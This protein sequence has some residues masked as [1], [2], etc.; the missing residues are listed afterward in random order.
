MYTAILNG[1]RITKVTP[2]LITEIPIKTNTNQINFSILYDGR[3]VKKGYY[4]ENRL[5]LVKIPGNAI[6]T[7]KSV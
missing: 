3:Q 6:S 2:K 7:S 5:I 1:N 4:T